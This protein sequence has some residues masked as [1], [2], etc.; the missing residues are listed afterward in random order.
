MQLRKALAALAA[1]A[2]LSVH[3]AL[4]ADLSIV[5]GSVGKD[6]QEMRAAL[7]AF[8]KES[9]HRVRIVEM[10]ASTTDQF[11]QYRL[12][13]AAGNADVDVYRTDVIWAP[14]LADNFVDLSEA[15]ADRVGEHFPAVID[16]QT[17]GGKLVA[18][19][20][21]TDAPTLYYRKDLLEKYGKQPPKTWAELEEIA[22]EIVTAERE[23][24][25]GG[26]NGFVFQGSAY[27]GLTCNALEWIA[28]SGG[29]TIVDE[30]GEITIDNPQAAAAIDR[31][32][33]WINKIAP[34]G[35]LGY[36]EEEARGVWQTG[37]AV[38]MRNWPYAY[39]LSRGDDSAVKDKFDV[40][41]LPMGEGGQPA[42]CLGGWNVAVSKHSP[43]QEAAIE[44]VRFLTSAE[45][46]KTRA[47]NQSRMPTIPS[48]Y[49]DPEVAEAQ[50][51][52]ANW[53]PVIETAT[54]RPS[55]ATKGK[56]NE[57]S[58]EFWTAVHQ[59]LSGRG[60]AASNLD[61]LDKALRRLKRAEW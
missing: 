54:A 34:G 32:A 45:W 20:L 13:L 48:V 17:V 58:K 10:P 61:R 55:A 18:M 57:M 11:G 56:Y 2:A 29:G 51:I 40:V 38:F 39:A 16:A 43:N 44:M 49:D 9:G 27:E 22:T 33:G 31:A 21:Y 6:V 25:N 12:W 42:G 3:P 50:P 4:A 24:G 28:S 23:A 60:D 53:K 26:L 35:V 37:N 1:T 30:A 14:Q 46:Q 36:M 7:D 19:P 15:M 41:Q 5:L 52:V 47:I 59:T 8:E